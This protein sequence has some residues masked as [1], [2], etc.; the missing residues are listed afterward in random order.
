MLSDMEVRCGCKDNSGVTQCKYLAFANRK[1][2]PQ[3]RLS[4]KIHLNLQIN[5][6]P[7]V[8]SNYRNGCVEFYLCLLYFYSLQRWS[9]RDTLAYLNQPSVT[10]QTSWKNFAI[11]RAGRPHRALL[12][13]QLGKKPPANHLI[14]PCSSVLNSEDCFALQVS[15]SHFFK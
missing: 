5:F 3:I 1:F 11:C 15:I 4:C 13:V 6:W 10:I 9:S 2:P 8:G 14:K 12:L 7:S